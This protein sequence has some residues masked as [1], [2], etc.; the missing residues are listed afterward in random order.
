MDGQRRIEVQ[1][2]KTKWAEKH[3]RAA[4][5]V[6][7]CRP[8]FV[9][10]TQITRGCRPG[11]C[12][13]QTATTP[14]RQRG[15][16]WSIAQVPRAVCTQSYVFLCV[17]GGKFWLVTARSTEGTELILSRGRNGLCCNTLPL[18]RVTIHDATSTSSW[19]ESGRN[20]G[21]IHRASLRHRMPQLQSRSRWRIFARA[22]TRI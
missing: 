18:Y 6:V 14:G 4:P 12:F 19:T 10:P 2:A 13:P 7:C 1:K 16:G 20:S 21:F 9:C 17:M 15:I 11:H 3:G 8:R 5:S 22:P